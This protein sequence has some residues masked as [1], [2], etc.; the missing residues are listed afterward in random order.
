[1]IETFIL[2]VVLIIAWLVW[3]AVRKKKPD[4]LKDLELELREAFHEKEKE[5]LEEIEELKLQHKEE[6]RQLEK[7]QNMEIKSHRQ[8]AVKRSR[9]TLIG[10]LWE[11]MAPYLPKFKYNPSDLRF[12]GSPIDY[13][14]FKGMSKKDIDSVIFLEIKSGDSKLTDQEENL[15]R[16]VKAGRVRWEE[17]RIK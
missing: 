2:L 15:K 5:Y 6:L 17:F 16:A 8:D 13:I 14:V 4:N 10:K 9:N 1:M 11:T 12:L 3:L 7:Q